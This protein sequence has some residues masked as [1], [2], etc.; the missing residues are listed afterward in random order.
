ML[1]NKL[2]SWHTLC[3]RGVQVNFG[4]ANVNSLQQKL[5]H[6]VSAA[7]LAV[8]LTAPSW[9]ADVITF[10]PTG[11]AGPSGNLSI[12][13]LDQKPGNAIALGAS[14]A[15]PT[16]TNFTLLYQSNLNSAD[17]MGVTQFSQTG[18]AG[19]HNFTFLA[20]FGETVVSNTP[21]PAGPQLAFGFDA[22]NPVNYFRMFHT[23]TAQGDNLSG[24]GFGA[25]TIILAG[26]IIGTDFSS[27]FQVT[28]GGPGTNLD[29]AN[30]D[31]Y[32]LIDTLSGSGSTKLTIVI[33]AF[34]PNFFPDLV[35]GGTVSFV[36]TSQAL[37][38]LQIDPS[39]CFHTA[40][41]IVCDQPGATLAS[42]GAVNG[43]TGPN[44]MFQADANASFDVTPAQVPEPMSLLLLS[45]GLLGLGLLRRKG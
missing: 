41:T 42:V 21:T 3:S 1:F 36:N 35:L 18:T 26:H 30:V 44:T 38:F 33:D 13:V 19:D 8:G 10:D 4:E 40:G 22:T 37:P 14:A 24:T 20:G 15:S 2:L 29:Q 45:A 25:G 6:S 11:T 23:T 7:V 32:P 5:L 9:A 12:D 31:N 43:A 28:G 39:A 17:L 16:G 27:N 34:D